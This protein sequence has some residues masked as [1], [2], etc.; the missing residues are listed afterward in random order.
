MKRQKQR[1]GDE[2]DVMEC[3]V[4]EKRTGNGGTIKRK[5]KKEEE[6]KMSNNKDIRRMKMK[7]KQMRRKKMTRKM[8]PKTERKAIKRNAEKIPE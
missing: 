3:E 6:I 8:T 1:E 2:D 4:I 7:K 5:E